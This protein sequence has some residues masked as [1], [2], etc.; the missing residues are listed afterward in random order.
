MRLKK[1]EDSGSRTDEILGVDMVEDAALDRALECKPAIDLPPGFAARLMERLPEDQPAAKA[2]RFGST[3]ATV[4]IGLIALVLIG[5]VGTDP[6][7][8]VAGRGFGFVFE[9]M[10]LTE[11]LAVAFWVGVRRDASDG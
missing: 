2:T 6:G 4:S 9:M 11:L 5:L 1:T 10:L 3:A 8:F 7:A